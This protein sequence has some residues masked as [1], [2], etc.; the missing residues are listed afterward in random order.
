MCD[1]VKENRSDQMMTGADQR[2]SYKHGKKSCEDKVVSCS[3]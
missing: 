3:D 1:Q 2:Y